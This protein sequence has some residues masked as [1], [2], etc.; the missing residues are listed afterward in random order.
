MQL[1]TI[2]YIFK[3]VPAIILLVWLYYV[4]A[5]ISILKKVRK[6]KEYADC[7]TYESIKKIGI[8]TDNKTLKEIYLNVKKQ[9]KRLLIIWLSSVF[10]GVLTILVFGVFLR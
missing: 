1:T 10:L 4:F 6:T 8:K 3:I 2:I 5:N 9:R 7:L